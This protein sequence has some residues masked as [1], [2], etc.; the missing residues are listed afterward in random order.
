MH[1]LAKV[2]TIHKA[3]SEK[4]LSIEK[5]IHPILTMQCIIFI[6]TFS[7]TFIEAKEKVNSTVKDV[8]RLEIERELSK[9][10]KKILK[11]L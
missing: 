10:T 2:L 6:W 4:S 3:N 7:H 5:V 1:R 8:T 9:H 11:F